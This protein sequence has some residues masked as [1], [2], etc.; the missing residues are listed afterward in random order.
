[1]IDRAL[2]MMLGMMILTF[3]FLG[4]QYLVGDVF[5]KTMPIQCTDGDLVFWKCS[6]YYGKPLKTYLI[7]YLDMGKITT[8]LS[9]SLDGTDGGTI[10]RIVGFALAAAYVAW[11]LIAILSGITI[12]Q[13]LWFLGVPIIIVTGIALVY[14][15]FLARA[16]LGYVRAV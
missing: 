6:D 8:L 9:A 15:I 13:L 14:Y 12:F 10:N 11:N 4:L 2:W 3:T 1:M 16:I 7:G 5:G